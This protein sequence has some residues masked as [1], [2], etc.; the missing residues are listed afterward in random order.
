M[1]RREGEPADRGVE[2]VAVYRAQQAADGRL[3]RAPLRG[4]YRDGDLDGQV[5]DP[6]GDRDE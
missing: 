2:P 4:A 3:R 6:L 1:V 5:R